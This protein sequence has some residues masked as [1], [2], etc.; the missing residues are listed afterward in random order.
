MT[1]KKDYNKLLL[2]LYKEL[3]KEKNFFLDFLYEVYEWEK[4]F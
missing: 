1:S 3:I 4:F 2:F